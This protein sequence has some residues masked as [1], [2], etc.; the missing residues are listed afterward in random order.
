MCSIF[1]IGT[2]MGRTPCTWMS[3]G[4]AMLTWCFSGTA[5]EWVD[6]Y[7][8]KFQ[9]FPSFEVDLS[10]QV[11]IVFVFPKLVIYIFSRYPSSA[12]AFPRGHLPRHWRGAGFL[13]IFGPNTW[14]SCSTICK[15]KH[16]TYSCYFLR[17]LF[18]RSK[19]F[20]RKAFCTFSII[21]Y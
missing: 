17:K 5:T 19:I 20:F 10:C 15:G 4:T 1:R 8:L 16:I 21:V 13:C 7:I 6:Y 14:W 12:R 9:Y 3:R 18:L 11:S 2:C